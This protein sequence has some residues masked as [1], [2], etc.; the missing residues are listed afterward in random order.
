MQRFDRQIGA[1]RDDTAVEIAILRHN[2]EIGRG[3]EITTITAPL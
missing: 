1:R 3:A 2:I